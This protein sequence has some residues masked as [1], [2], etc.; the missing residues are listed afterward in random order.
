MTTEP[1]NN[2]QNIIAA[3]KLVY[4]DKVIDHAIN[5][6]NY[7]TLSNADGTGMVKADCGD[8]VQFWI[9]VKKD[10]INKASF[11][12]SGCAAT[13]A[14][15][16]IATEMVTGKKV[17][18]AYKITY[19]DIVEA[20]DGLPTG[21]IDGAVLAANSI[22]KAIKDYLSYKNDPWKKAYRQ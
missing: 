14:C 18:E 12:T 22:Q 15:G 5:A 4:S 8:T 20:L 13:V 17:L 11:I 16:S 7:G 6:R 3:M 21:N 9:R 19:N 10:V 1:D 2:L